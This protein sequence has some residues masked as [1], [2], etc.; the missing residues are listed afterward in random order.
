M[1]AEKADV[2]SG[3]AFNVSLGKTFEGV[4]L[5]IAIRE[6][7]AG[8]KPLIISLEGYKVN[9]ALIQEKTGWKPNHSIAEGLL[10][11]I[12]WYKKRDYT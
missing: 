2:L 5:G 8:Q 6:M 9:N 11:T 12:E 3:M 7:V 4:S 10:K 1:L